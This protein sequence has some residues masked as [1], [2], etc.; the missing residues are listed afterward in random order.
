[1]VGRQH[2]A[3]RQRVHDLLARE[4]E[5]RFSAAGY[6]EHLHDEHATRVP[7]DVNSPPGMK[8]PSEGCFMP[9]GY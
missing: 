2:G 4:V 3:S 8:N 6:F 5:Y 1:M 9:G 7:L